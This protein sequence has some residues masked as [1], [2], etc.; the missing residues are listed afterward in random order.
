MLYNSDMMRTAIIQ[1]GLYISANLP[2]FAL[3][4]Q[5]LVCCPQIETSQ[6]ICSLWCLKR[7][8]EG[9]NIIFWLTH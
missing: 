7:F 4:R 6:L 2:D 3:T 9:L 8:Y 5:V 1:S